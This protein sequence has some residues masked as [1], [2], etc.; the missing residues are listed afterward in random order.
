MLWAKHKSLRAFHLSEGEDLKGRFHFELGCTH[1][2][3]HKSLHYAS[4]YLTI[5]EYVCG[6]FSVLSFV[7]WCVPY[8]NSLQYGIPI[9][10]ST[11]ARVA[12]SQCIV[13]IWSE[14]SQH[15]THQSALESSRP[16]AQV[17]HNQ[18]DITPSP[19]AESPYFKTP[20]LIHNIPL[21]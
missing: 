5:Y 11:R 3:N 2:L 13:Q 9:G 1:E 4:T 6:Y 15:K 8:H 16:L 10:I 17:L 14:R 20:M 21:K 7:K 19:S 18:I 12:L